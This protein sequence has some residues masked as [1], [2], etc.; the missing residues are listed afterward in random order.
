[1]LKNTVGVSMWSLR[2]GELRDSLGALRH[3]VLGELA[4]KGQPHRCLNLPG[5]EGLGLVDLPQLP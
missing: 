4:G 5:C 3:G 2:G 1:M